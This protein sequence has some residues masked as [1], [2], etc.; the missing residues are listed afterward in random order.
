MGLGLR[1]VAE[2]DLGLRV[3]AETGSGLRVEGSEGRRNQ[4]EL[5]SHLRTEVFG[6]LEH[7]LGLAVVEFL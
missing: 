4:G 5:P 7:V 1:V 3:V 6:S 2:M